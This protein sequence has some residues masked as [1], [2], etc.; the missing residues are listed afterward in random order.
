MLS[1]ASTRPSFDSPS[2]PA[3]QAAAAIA[4]ANLHRNAYN[5]AFYQLGLRWH[6]NDENYR[7]VL[8]ADGERSC[9]RS[10]LEQQQSHLLKAY[11]VDFLI[12]A[13]LDAKQRCYQN[14]TGAG[15]RGAAF[16][17]WAELQQGQVGS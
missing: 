17:D 9:L 2:P 15:C 7:E 8:C 12:D 14:M 16:T 4:D 10:Y 5:A 1:S 13:I 3:D 11:D 6:W